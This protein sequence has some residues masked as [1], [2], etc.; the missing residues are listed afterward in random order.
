M[1]WR[2]FF[3]FVKERLG[4]KECPFLDFNLE[5]DL[6]F[7]AARKFYRNHLHNGIVEEMMKITQEMQN[8]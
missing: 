3:E 4:K 2:Y 8:E 1:E 6:N 7:R 5:R